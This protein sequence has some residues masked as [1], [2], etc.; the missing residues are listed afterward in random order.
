MD[1]YYK[2]S[3]DAAP[4]LPNVPDGHKCGRLH[5]HTY[6][7]T[8]WCSGAVNPA[9]SASYDNETGEMEIFTTNKHFLR[10]GYDD[11]VILSGFTFSPSKSLI[12]PIS[13]DKFSVIGITSE[14]S[15]K[16]K[17]GTSTISHT[18]SVAAGGTVRPWYGDLT[19]GSGYNTGVTTNGV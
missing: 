19:F 1:I 15:F 5:G 7:I 4:L 14:K 9:L 10:V 2:T 12:Q 6:R 11:E 16:V 18:V 8:I 13:N 17:L 3:I